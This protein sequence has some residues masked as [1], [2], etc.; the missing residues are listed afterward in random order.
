MIKKEFKFKGK[1]V[2]ELEQM[3]IDEF[4]NICTSRQKKSLKKGFDKKMLKKIQNAKAKSNP[5]PIKTHSRD[6]IVIPAMIG[7]KFA[8]HRGN[9]FEAVDINEKM[10]GHYLGEF[11]FTRK[12]LMHGKAGIGATRSST[13]ITAR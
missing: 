2:P 9:V 3:S 13:A 8:V 12:R 1:T 7:L 5:K 11:V 6:I 4:A 10:L